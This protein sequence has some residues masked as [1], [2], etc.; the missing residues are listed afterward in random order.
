MTYKDNPFNGCTIVA[1][2]KLEHF[3]RDS[4]NS[5]II[6]LGAT[7]G[8]AVTKSTNYLICGKK[9]GNKLEKAQKLGKKSPD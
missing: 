9:A 1:T 5:K 2:G 4:I 7:A 8:S 3:T 6:R